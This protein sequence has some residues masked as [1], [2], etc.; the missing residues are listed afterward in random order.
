MGGGDEDGLGADAVHVDA[1]PGLEVVE[2]DVAVLGN[3]VCY[4]VFV[5][6]LQKRIKRLIGL[7]I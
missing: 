4:S 5:R 1:H 6:Y 7:P 3:Q 2:V